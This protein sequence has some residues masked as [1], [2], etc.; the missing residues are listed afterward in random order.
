[1]RSSLLGLTLGL[2]IASLVATPVR[3]VETSLARCAADALGRPAC[4]RDPRGVAVKGDLGEVRC[5][6]GACVRAES[7]QPTTWDDEW[8][9]S[10]VAGG[11]AT[12]TESGPRCDGGCRPPRATD[13]EEH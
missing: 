12:L 9:C 11:A 7:P 3:A 5:A 4:A 6:P 2:T 13:C 10:G 8:M 1:M